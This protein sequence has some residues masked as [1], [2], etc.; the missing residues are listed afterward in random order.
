MGETDIQRQVKK[1]YAQ[2]AAIQK[3]SSS[4]YFL[5]QKSLKIGKWTRSHEPIF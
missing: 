4:L 2:A 5:F 1:A 3:L